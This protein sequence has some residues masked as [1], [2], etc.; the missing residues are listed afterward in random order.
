MYP[1]LQT[2]KRDRERNLTKVSY[3]TRSGAIVVRGRPSQNDHLV[4][5]SGTLCDYT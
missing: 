2:L 1:L 5:M 4:V 3:Q